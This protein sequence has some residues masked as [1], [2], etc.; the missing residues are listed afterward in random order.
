MREGGFIG[1]G[2]GG[3]IAVETADVNLRE[4]NVR[5]EV[6]AAPMCL[7]GGEGLG[8]PGPCA[9]DLVHEP[10]GGGFRC[11]RQIRG[12]K[13]APCAHTVPALRPRGVK[14]GVVVGGRRL[15][16]DR[17]DTCG[18][19]GLA[20][21]KGSPRPPSE[22]GREATLCTSKC[23]EWRVK[24][25]AT[26]GETEGGETSRWEWRTSEWKRENSEAATPGGRVRRR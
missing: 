4:F 17:G 5:R 22:R 12:Q 15:V 14:S 8:D 10:G 25:R 18:V 20:V 3:S 23:S 24:S 16:G 1:S 21:G 2:R 19:K 11:V 7:E 26:S 9:G 6:R 13:G